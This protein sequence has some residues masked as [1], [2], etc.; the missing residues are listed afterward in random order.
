MDSSSAAAASA[1]AESNRRNADLRGS[2]EET[3]YLREW[4]RFKTFVEEKR[5]EVDKDLAHMDPS[6][7]PMP[8]RIGLAPAIQGR[9][10]GVFWHQTREQEEESRP[11]ETEEFQKM[12]GKRPEKK[13]RPSAKARERLE[14]LSKEKTETDTPLPERFC[15]VSSTTTPRSKHRVEKR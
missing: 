8:I 13:Q 6:C 2:T 7:F 9:A 11:K 10:E 12:T 1:L 4:K 15:K 3:T 5:K 14:V